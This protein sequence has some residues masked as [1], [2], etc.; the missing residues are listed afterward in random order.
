MRLPLRYQILLPFAALFVVAIG[1]SSALGAYLAARSSHARIETQLTEIARTLQ[2]SSFPLTGAVLRQTRGLS[3]AE[4]VVLSP[5][6]LLLAAS[7]PF[8]PHELSLP[9]APATPARRLGNIVTIDGEAYFHSVVPLTKRVDRAEPGTLHILFPERTWREARWQAAVPPL[10]LGGVSLLA[11]VVVAFALAHRL[12]RPLQKL[13][14]QVGRLASGDFERVNMPARHDE[15]GDLVESVNKLADQLDE[16][17]R[18][19]KRAERLSLLGQLS[20]GLAH[21]LRNDL[22]GARIALQLIESESSQVDAES[23]QVALRQLT[24]AEQHLQQ[25]LA[26]GQPRLPAFAACDLRQV[27]EQLVALVTPRF[28]HLQV[29][30]ETTFSDDTL[31]L[32]ADA[33]QLRQALLNLV[34]NAQEA[35]GPGG[36]VRVACLARPKTNAIEVAVRDNGPGVAAHVAERLFEPFTTSKKEG[37]GL[38]LAVARQLI[39]AHGGTLEYRRSGNVTEFVATLPAEFHRSGIRENSDESQPIG[40]LS[41]SAALSSK[42]SNLA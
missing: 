13:R 4:F 39:E 25:F 12:T 31:P 21:H 35:A 33:E 9:T 29:R 18:A 41:S 6:G 11:V 17:R 27:I 2:T 20:G 5:Q 24:L 28:H 16:L 3:G 40:T 8:S 1:L 36:W 30:L 10:V 23:L 14:E 38:G 32:Q 34:L 26:A 22:A 15:I 7:H 42:S 37:V 19:I